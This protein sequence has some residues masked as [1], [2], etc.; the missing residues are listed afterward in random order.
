MEKNSFNENIK[1]KCIIIENK[2]ILEKINSK[3]IINNLLSFILD[4]T[5]FLKLFLY[6]KSLQNKVNIHLYDYI[7]QYS[8]K[9]IKWEDY[10]YPMNYDIFTK[11]YLKNSL[12]KKL[13]EYNLK[14][15]KIIQKI[16]INYFRNKKINNDKK[17]CEDDFDYIIDIFSPFF[18]YLVKNDSLTK[19]FTI[20]IP[21]ETIKK[22]NLKKYYISKFNELNELKVKY[23][24]LSLSFNEYGKLNY[25]KDIKINTNYIEK[26]NFYI[27][28]YCK[29]EEPLFKTIDNIFNLIISSTNLISLSLNFRSI[30]IS[31]KSFIFINQL[32]SLKYLKLNSIIFKD[33]FT[34]NLSNLEILNISIC[35]NIDFTNDVLLN[36]KKIALFNEI[37][38]KKDLIRGSELEVIT[39]IYKINKIIDCKSL[40]KLKYFNG[41]LKDFLLLDSPLLEE[42][43]LKNDYSYESDDEMILIK[44]LCSLKFLK[45]IYLELNYITEEEII[46]IKSKNTSIKEIHIELDYKIEGILYHLQNIFINLKKLF[47]DIKKSEEN[48]SQETIIKIEENS[49]S[50]VTNLD[51]KIS[52]NENYKI[53][54]QSYQELESI[55][56]KNYDEDSIIKKILPIFNDKCD[57]IFKSLKIFDYYQSYAKD[58]NIL[59]NIYNN[60]DNIPNIEEFYIKFKL[61]DISKKFYKSFIE[62]ILSNK[63]IK[64]ASINIGNSSEELSITELKKIFPNINFRKFI[65]IN[66]YKRD[67]YDICCIN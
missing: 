66:I 10:L 15:E 25:L 31:S 36:L 48:K 62:K 49:N 50:K 20:I 28:F 52:K 30:N 26:L 9:R 60:L 51:I 6:S 35:Q 16:V 17:L 33:T 47:I 3:Y 61:K 2:S 46:K 59:K 40:K 14:D 32:K 56:F 64:I 22:H 29:S 21:T 63:L 41:N 45:I 55:R 58:I 65:K 54:C 38:D 19:F 39:S 4:K 13:L 1:S 7:E 34:L 42:V 44:K 24:S 37:P 27:D 12:E 5:F 23:N 67:N 53:C 18:N 57:I 8:N 11:D 43:D